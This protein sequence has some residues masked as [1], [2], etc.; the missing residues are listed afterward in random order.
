MSHLIPMM[1][2]DHS[3][4]VTYHMGQYKHNKW[5]SKILKNRENLF[6]KS[7]K[8][9]FTLAEL[10]CKEQEKEIQKL[11]LQKRHPGKN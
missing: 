6:G 9:P 1:T 5:D 2:Y 7:R 11:Y 10:H 8:A 4:K 3:N